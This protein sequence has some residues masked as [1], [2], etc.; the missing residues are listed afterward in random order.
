MNS[1]LDRM[2]EALFTFLLH[3][4]QLLGVLQNDNK[5][6]SLNI[7]EKIYSAICRLKYD[8]INT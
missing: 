1:G 8:L 7:L 5:E 6:F 3:V 2:S 4:S